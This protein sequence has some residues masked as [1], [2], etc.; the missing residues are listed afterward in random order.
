MK[1]VE[2]R[3]RH[4]PGSELAV[5]HL[6]EQDR[7]VYFEFSPE[8][9]ESGFEV[10]P[11]RLPAGPG[12]V[13]HRPGEF[14]P[15]P[16]VFDDSLP[17]GWGR[18]LM[19]RYFRIEGIEPD[20]MS[21]LDRL[22][23]LGTRTMG[24]LTYHPSEESSSPS[25]LELH[26]LAGQAQRV[27]A[28]DAERLLPEL[29]RAGGSPGGARP[30]IL[31]GRKEGEL[32][33]GEDDLP[34]GFEH[35]LIKFEGKG[36]PAS[37]GA[38]EQAYSTMARE[39]GI[40]FPPTHLFETREGGRYFGV[41]RFDRLPGNRRVHMHTLGG[42]IHSNFRVPSCDYDVFLNVTRELTKNHEDLV[43]AYRRMI[44]NVVAANRDDHVK[45]FAFLMNSSG[46]W[47]LSPAFDV[48]YSPGPGG[49]HSM[50][51]GGQEEP[52]REHCLAMAERHGI[53]RSTAE[54][55]LERVNSAVANWGRHAREAGCS[56]R[57]VTRIVKAHNPL[58]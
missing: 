18:L 35:W 51:I 41:R 42:L 12:L 23:Y 48:T 20:S 16:G 3:L 46:E 37:A 4:A 54:E 5:G 6:A 36:D 33:S 32:L 49:H 25:A 29:L 7:R 27:M 2:V 31:V 53:S 19:D 30:K 26:G 8:F 24:A 11:W 14:G 44:F 45:N 1:K 28:G 40:D 38:I 58:R 17:D 9:L 10:S 55:I 43:E 21:A 15:L 39:A 13:E 50:L 52:T 56:A 57:D 22:L 34:E 47:V